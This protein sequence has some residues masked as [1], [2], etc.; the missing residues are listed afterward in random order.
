MMVITCLSTQREANTP[1][2][3]EESKKV[4]D[5]YYERT[6][7]LEKMDKEGKYT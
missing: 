2:T 6:G 5:A 3:K 4:W 7:Q 1:L